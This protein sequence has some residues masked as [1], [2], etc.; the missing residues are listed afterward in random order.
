MK[1]T[2]ELYAE[3]IFATED[4]KK[5]FENYNRMMN[6]FG[7]G[8]EPTQIKKDNSKPKIKSTSGH[9]PF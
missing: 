8:C 2:K 6:Q 7:Q 9:D 1:R 5:K 3:T 4:E